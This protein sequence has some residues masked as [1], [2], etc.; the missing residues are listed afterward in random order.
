M[1]ELLLDLGRNGTPVKQRV[2]GSP[3]RPLRPQFIS[4]IGCKNVL[5]EGIALN[6]GP[7]WTVHCVYCENVIVRGITI[8]NYG[9]NNDGV[10]L[11]SCRN[12]LIEQCEF[13]TGDDCI[14]L[15]SGINEDGWRVGRATENVIIRNCLMREGHGSV[16]IGSDTSGDIRNV[17]AHDCRSLGTDRGF[18]LKSAR[19][20]GGVVENIWLDRMHWE[21]LH[22]PAIA[23]NAFY[24]AW[25][26]SATGKAPVFRNIHLRRITCESAR[27]AAEIVGLPDQHAED[28]TFTDLT[29]AAQS[30]IHA[31]AATRL[32]LRNCT[33]LPAHGPAVVLKDC[34]HVSVDHLRGPPAGILLQ[35]E[36]KRI[37]KIRLDGGPAPDDDR[38]RAGPDVEP[39]QLPRSGRVD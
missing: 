26:V 19:G 37:H 17:Y 29:L 3:D 22:G 16:V 11:D 21:Q 23:I 5:I 20:R 25:A 6:S 9:P 36:G 39:G 10:N 18:R 27:V 28:V 33:V 1:A 34:R 14:A 7:F 2:F 13:N 12:A 4:P 8:D 30:G 31:T 32:K 15:K 38:L 35:V 24:R